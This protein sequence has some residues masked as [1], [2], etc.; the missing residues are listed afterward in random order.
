MFNCEVRM[1]E[2][3]AYLQDLGEVKPLES[4]STAYLGNTNKGQ[5]LQTKAR[6]DNATSRW[7]TDVNFLSTANVKN[8]A[9]DYPISYKKPGVQN[10]VYKNVRLAKYDI[11]SVVNLKGQSAEKA[12]KSLYSFI[13]DSKKAD[14]RYLL[15]QHGKGFQSDQS[16][17]SLKSYLAVWLPQFDDVLAFHSALPNHGGASSTYV[18]LKKSDEARL[19]NKERHQKRHGHRY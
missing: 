2:F 7:A 1:N 9:P 10:G 4:S 13:L 8:I 12:R 5:E 3:D 14:V 17:P 11:Q 19:D 15:I 6:R 16:N 18:L